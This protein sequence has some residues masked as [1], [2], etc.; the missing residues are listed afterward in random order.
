MAALGHEVVGIDVDPVRVAA[1]RAGRV[2]FHE[3]GLE[4]LLA[5][6]VASGRLR[7]STDPAAARASADAHFLCVGTP[8]G[9]DRRR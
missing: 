8:Q 2:P 5:R 3:P 7:F 9:P 4:A 6:Q 1:L